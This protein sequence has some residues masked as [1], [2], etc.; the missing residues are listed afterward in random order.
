MWEWGRALAEYAAAAAWTS[1]TETAPKYGDPEEWAQTAEGEPEEG[2]GA[3]IA[4]RDRMAGA[5]D[6]VG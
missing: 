5:Y 1:S 6:L 4:A 3:G 2:D